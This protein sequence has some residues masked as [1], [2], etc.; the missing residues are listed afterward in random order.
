[1]AAPG[2]GFAPCARAGERGL[3]RVPGGPLILRVKKK[4]WEFPCGAV[5]TAMIVAMV[6]RAQE[7]WYVTG[8]ISVLAVLSKYAFRTRFRERI[9]SGG[10]GDCRHVLCFSYGPELVGRA[11]GSCRW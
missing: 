6:L 2:Q 9:Q 11:D 7:P 1:M 5:L 10:A 4:V 3:R 8:I